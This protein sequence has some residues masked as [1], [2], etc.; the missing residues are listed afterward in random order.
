[1]RLA[2]IAV[3]CAIAGCASV[4]LREVVPQQLVAEAHPSGFG[5]IRLWGDASEADVLKFIAGD[6]ATVEAKWRA[7]VVDKGSLVYNILAISGGADDG[8][9]GAGVL[10]GWEDA[11]SRP[12]FD[13][14]TGI[15]AGGL[16]APLAFLGR[17]YDD[18]LESVFTKHDS[19]QIY[20]ATIFAG[21]F[22]GSSL[23]DS[24]PLQRLIETYVNHELMR[25]VAEERRKGRLLIIGTTNIDAQRPVFWDM[26]RIAQ[27]DDPQ[28]LDLF[29]KVLLASASIPGVFAPVH[30]K[31]TAGGKTYEELHVDGGATRQVFL[32]PGDFSFKTIDQRLHRKVERR[33]YII[34]N[35]KLGPEWAETK[36]TTIDLA[37][38]SLSTLTKS[39][40]IGD[41]VRMY[42]KA[43]RDGIDFNLIAIPDEFS[44][45]RK[46]PFELAYM[47]PLY[48]TGYKIGNGGVPWL[49]KAPGF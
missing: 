33:L 9:F 7:R 41:L 42:S 37:Q 19:Q 22:G 26:G 1:M 43:E 30:I 31:V 39:Q 11:G 16:I 18:E 27:S 12:D 3:A 25:R 29:R 17:D 40:G 2:A 36:E 10:N 44:A 6:V 8:A 45:P 24:S 49:K 14:V 48:D 46:R 20:E 15:S 34:R 28:A 38:R 13:L 21:L 4:P 23:A 35:G 5:N 32:A 47:R